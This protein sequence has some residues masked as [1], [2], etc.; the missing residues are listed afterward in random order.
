LLKHEG[1]SIAAAYKVA[2]RKVFVELHVN[3]HLA[4]GVLCDLASETT[5]AYRGTIFAVD[6]RSTRVAHWMEPRT[7]Q[8][9][10]P[11]RL[12]VAGRPL[13]ALLG[14]DCQGLRWDS[15]GAIVVSLESGFLR[16]EEEVASADHQR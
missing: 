12:L 9:G 13:L 2:D 11:G 15:R 5:Q 10:E 16:I 7:S 14:H 3:P 1:N 8:P 4:V 6:E